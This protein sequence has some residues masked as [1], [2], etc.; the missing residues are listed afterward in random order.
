M[1][2]NVRSCALACFVA[3]GAHAQ[4]VE[5][6]AEARYD[7][8]LGFT[9]R[10]RVMEVLVEPGARVSAGEALARLDDRESEAQLRLLAVRA[11]STLEAEAAHAEWLLAEESEKRIRAALEQGGANPFEVR[12]AELETL[13]KKLGHELF[14]ERQVEASLRLEQAERTHE[15]FT[16]LSPID[17]VVESVLIDPGELVEE[18]RPVIRVVNTESLRIDAPA[19]VGIASGVGVGDGVWV[20]FKSSPGETIRGTVTHV[21]SVADPGSETRIVRVEIEN[22]SGMPG[23]SHVQVFFGGPPTPEN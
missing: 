3:A 16:L 15:Q 10:G 22:G 12:E 19:P 13:R 2:V 21:A 5:A 17:G 23:G 8:D 14:V 20:R 6:I 18:V 1:R 9:L 11:E 4:P 7:V